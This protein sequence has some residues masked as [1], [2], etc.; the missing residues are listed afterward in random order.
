MRLMLFLLL[1][2]SEAVVPAEPCVCN[3]SACKQQQAIRAIQGKLEQYYKQLPKR[4]QK[5]PPAQLAPKLHRA[6]QEHRVHPEAVMR[7][8]AVESNFNALAIN[9]RTAD[10][11]LMQINARTA[12]ALNIHKNCLMQWECNLQ[13]GIAIMAYMQKRGNLCRY[14]VGVR[15]LVGKRLSICNAYNR[16]LASIN[17]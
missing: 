2:A 11:G 14:N 16:K 1:V 9:H 4:R 5:P 10:Y 15:P 7:L 3:T 12:K 13:A 17:L 6:W 8:I